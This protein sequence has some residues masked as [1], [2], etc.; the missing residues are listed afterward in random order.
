[1][2]SHF[3]YACFFV[4]VLAV[5]NCAA[6]EKPHYSVLVPLGG[7]ARTDAEADADFSRVRGF[8]SNRPVFVLGVR[9]RDPA[10]RSAQMKG[11]AQ[12]VRMARARGLGPVAAWTWSFWCS[13]LEGF[14]PM[15]ASDGWKSTTM[16]C[17]LCPHFRAFAGD[18][19]VEMVK[20][21]VDMVLLD[22]DYRYGQLHDDEL[23][24]TCPLHMAK[25]ERSLG[26]RITPGELKRKV[27]TGGRNRWRDAWMKA[28]GDALKDFA[29]YLRC[30]V[31]EVNPKVRLGL[32]AVM[33]HWDNDGVD[34]ATTARILAGGTQPFLRLIG[35]PYWSVNRPFYD[36]RL[37]NI[38]EF[39]RMERS[40]ID[41]SDIEVV[42]EGDTYP[43]PRQ[44][45]PASYLELFDL[46]LRTTGEMDGILKYGIDYFE[47]SRE[48]GYLVRHRK[49][50]PVAIEIERAFGGKTAV[51]LRIYET[52]NRLRDVEIPESVS[53]TT[54]IFDLFG[55][56]AA[57]CCSDLGI[58][59]VWWGE[60]LAGVAFGPNIEAVP[61][62]ARRRGLVIDAWA[63]RL[64]MKR[65][66]DVGIRSWGEKYMAG[67]DAGPF[68]LGGSVFAYEA[69]RAVPQEGAEAVAYDS[70]RKTPVAFVY[71]NGKGEKYMV[72]PYE[73]YFNKPAWHRSYRAG[74]IFAKGVEM[75]T[76]RK[77]PAFAGS[78]PD[79]YVIAKD[80]ADG[81]R[82]VG[83]FN[84]FADE[85]V[86]Q[87]VELDRP[88]AS[89]HFVNCRGR[90][91][92]GRVILESVPAWTFAGFEVSGNDS[93]R[94]P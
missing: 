38:V 65:G 9:E 48:D 90:L 64:L 24:C 11:L 59:T 88:F 62:E 58:P 92:G 20:C 3:S 49:H 36:A 29:A 40:W 53:G 22:D 32:C 74:R 41:G 23:L 75:L 85:L 77:L 27:L 89:A 26:E 25:I 55:S 12:N 7:A 44:F 61:D 45:C 54:K 81:A 94:R 70:D 4:G 67:L 84:M 76:G 30:R 72:L 13:S 15:G 14:T 68:G 18:Y 5:S 16:A 50:R 28:N 39:S 34:A 31:D 80:G 66:V 87:V 52:K 8:D 33:S 82:A 86:D 69:Y 51:G 78:S 79:V 21:G 56:E 19:V 91:E 6:L 57:K 93:G 35:A 73:T 37:Q 71:R 43:R 83:V 1:M 2:K 60:G 46:A 10:V 63:A 42:G 17:P 47:P